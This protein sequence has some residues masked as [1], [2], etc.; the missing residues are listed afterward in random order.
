LGFAVDETT[1]VP[2]A[3]AY[4]LAQ[5][6]APPATMMEAIE[7]TG[8]A[9]AV[10]DKAWAVAVE[11]KPLQR[12]TGDIEWMPPVRGYKVLGV[13]INNDAIGKIAEKSAAKPATFLKAA[14]SLIGH[15]QPVVIRPEYGL[16]HP[17]GELAVV[18]G[19]RGKFI[20]RESA[21]DHVFGYMVINDITSVSMKSEDTYVWADPRLDWTPPGFEHGNMQLA[22][23]GRS[24]G[25]DTFGPCGPW[26]V[27]RDE[28]PDPN[29]L[30]V[31]VYMG[32]ELCAE[33]HTGNLRHTVPEVIEWVSKFYTLE[34][35]DVIHMG[36]A[37]HG[38]YGLRELDFQS[39]DGPCTVEI[40]K[41][42]RLVSPIVRHD[43]EG[44]PVPPKPK[45]TATPWPPRMTSR[46]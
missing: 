37:A 39:W 3:D 12:S 8:N 16:T 14:S 2:V 35:G 42:G 38:K 41:V 10:L 28:I 7:L 43:A 36:T 30:A 27:T 24:K 22:Y 20:T 13:A 11:T 29:D 6:E 45:S 21:F 19:R 1:I 17:E 25:T 15:G 26:I 31:R 46:R 40:E 32:E 5:L 33:D 44:Q 34:P 4:R 18:I 23:H 9:R